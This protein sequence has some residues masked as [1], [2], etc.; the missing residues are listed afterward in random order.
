VGVLAGD[1]GG[2]RPGIHGRP[3]E[4][5]DLEELARVKASARASMTRADTPSPPI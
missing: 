1:L 4:D 5:L 3:L 2:G